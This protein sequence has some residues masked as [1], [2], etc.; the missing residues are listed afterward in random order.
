MG[1]AYA[2]VFIMRFSPPT[3]LFNIAT[4]PVAEKQREALMPA[5]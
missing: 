4:A 3:L 1:A 2:A 5:I